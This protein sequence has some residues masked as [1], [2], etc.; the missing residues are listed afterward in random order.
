MRVENVER[1][2]HAAIEE[3]N[4]ENYG[5]LRYVDHKIEYKREQKKLDM[6][7]DKNSKN[8][9]KKINEYRLRILSQDSAKNL[10]GVAEVGPAL[11]KN[12][13]GNAKEY[14][15]A[16]EQGR[17]CKGLEYSLGKFI[18]NQ[19]QGDIKF[20]FMQI[21]T[22]V[23]TFCDIPIKSQIANFPGADYTQI[24]SQKKISSRLS[25]YNQPLFMFFR[26]LLSS[27]LF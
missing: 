13:A 16:E 1:K 4:K 11:E 8:Y 7:K 15:A 5:E 22:I 9:L 14:G 6:K 3:E 25:R 19:L 27:L 26:Q 23:L 17:R 2:Y 20:H 24:E 21:I 18:H 12:I 10:V